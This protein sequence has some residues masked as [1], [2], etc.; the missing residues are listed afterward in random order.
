VDAIGREYAQELW[1]DHCVIGSKGAEIEETL[2]T[3]F[4]PW[5]EKMKI[6]RKVGAAWPRHDHHHNEKGLN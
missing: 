4:K 6:S 2:R 3:A 1:P 5:K